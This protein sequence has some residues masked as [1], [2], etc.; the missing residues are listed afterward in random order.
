MSVELFDKYVEG[1]LD[2]EIVTGKYVR[3]C[4]ERHVNDLKRQNTED[5]P[6][7]FNEKVASQAIEAFPVLFRHTVGSY[8]GTPFVLSP[9]QA[10]VVGS[11]WGWKDA[12]NLRRFNRAYVTLSRKQGKALSLDTK[13][14][15]P[16]GLTTMG[17]VKVGDYLIGG[18]GRPV[19]VEA[20]TEVMEGRPCLELEFTTGEKVVCDE[21]HE[22]VTRTKSELL[23]GRS[24]ST[25]TAK[26][27]SET[28]KCGVARPENNHRIESV[29]TVGDEAELPIQPYSFGVWLGDGSSDGGRIYGHE[30][31]MKFILDRMVS[32]GVTCKEVSSGGKADWN[33]TYSVQF[34]ESTP[35]KVVLREAGVLKNKH[36]PEAYFHAS[37]EQRM[38]LLSGLMDTDGTVCLKGQCEFT[39]KSGQLVR[40]VARLLNSLGVACSVRYSKMMLNGRDVGEK[41]RIHFY[42]PNWMTDSYEL[43]TISRKQ[44]RVRRRKKDGTRKVVNV[45][46]V[47]SVPV[48]CVQVEGGTY[49]C[50][51]GHI[52]THNSTLAAGIAILMAAFDNEPQA[53]C[54]IGA[55]K[56]DQ[57]K[58]IF[59]ECKRMI[60]SNPDLAKQF[61]RR[62]LQ[63]NHDPSNS[64]I[65]PLGSDRAFDGLNPSLVLFDELHVWRNQHRDFYNTLTTGSAARSQPMRFTITT[66]GSTSSNIWVEEQTLA[67]KLMEGTYEEERYFAFLAQLDKDDNIFDEANWPKSM[68][69]LNVS[70][71]PDYIREAAAEA[72]TSKV[73]E[74]RFRRYFANVQVSPLEQAIDV[75]KWNAC[76][77]ELTDWKK[78]DTICAGIDIGG[79]NDMASLAFV[80]R[81]QDGADE[82]GRTSYRYEVK[83]INYMDSDTTRDLNEMPW[84]QFISDK[85]IK[86]VDYIHKSIYDDVTSAMLEYRQ[87]QIAFDPWNS[88]Q[89]AEELDRDGFQS[90]QVQQNRYKMNEPILLLLDL[91]DKRKIRFSDDK[92]LSWCASNMVLNF[93]SAGRCLPDKSESQGKIDAIVATTMALK[94]ASLAPERP[95]GNFFVT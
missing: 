62:A 80:A 21:Q 76:E 92:V 82:E 93:D 57:A 66:A 68:P 51:E 43:F 5:F 8:A 19:V 9:W 55:S 90:V 44:V 28:V 73:A 10:F 2:G 36:I 67:E 25:K 22:W 18:S 4:V 89:L 40:D 58:I 74:N 16:T 29:V 7:T 87:K 75:E 14:P 24:P 6:Y 17:E 69:N 71:S 65:R 85:R 1:V 15:T 41:G 70:V 38:A 72:K 91:I 64:F 84:L 77:G 3:L 94:L 27:I 50:G 79:R 81:F 13:L 23:S 88:Q 86:V 46:K 12:R 53:Q 26:E 48:K 20:V 42:P 34:S 47:E 63:I 60:G 45:R 95:R 61:D 35:A 37:I 11:L 52:L 30:D 32:E 33:K 31:D 49:L 56:I 59:E 39:Q 54:Y 83:T 78:A